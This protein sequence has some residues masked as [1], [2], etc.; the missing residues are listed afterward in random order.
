MNKGFLF[1][2][3]LLVTLGMF[4][5]AHSRE[6]SIIKAHAV[7]PSTLTHSSYLIGGAVGKIDTTIG[8]FFYDN[9]KLILAYE[10]ETKTK[11]IVD[12]TQFIKNI[13]EDLKRD[14]NIIIRHAC[15]GVPGNP[16]AYQEFIQPFYISFAVDALEIIRS[17]DLETVKVMNDFEVIGYGIDALH[18]DSIIQINPRIARYHGAK[19]VVGAG[20]GVGSC[21]MVWDALRSDYMS[22]S[23]GFCYSDFVAQNH[24]ELELC[25]FVQKVTPGYNVSW[26][27]MLGATSG[28]IKMYDFLKLKHDQSEH[29]LKDTNIFSVENMQDIFDRA[30][31]NTLCKESVALYMKLY[32]RLIRNVAYTTLPYGGLYITNT[33]A[34]KNPHLFTNGLFFDEFLNCN[35]DALKEILQEIPLYVITD[36]KVRLYGAAR[37]LL[38]TMR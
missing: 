17:T 34:E 8:V 2:W 20:A 6:L 24:Y 15:F 37:Y 13:L 29:P 1:S 14:Y 31:T 3:T 28:I 16:S 21:L 12:F 38:I 19:A 4:F 32:T 33:T 22:S 23:L 7:A 27:K 11:N 18:P 30:S 36:P 26:G 10:F 9:D 5:A 25:E 35:N